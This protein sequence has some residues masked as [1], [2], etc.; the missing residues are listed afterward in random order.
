M[1]VDRR[2]A[3]HLVHALDQ[4]IRDRVLELFRFLV[5]LVPAHAENLHQEELDQPVAAQ[6]VES[7]TP[8]GLR[9]L[10]T[11]VG[12]VV[13]QTALRQGL[14]HRRDRAWRDAQIVGDAPHADQPRGPGLR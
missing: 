6:N 5:D 1:R 13:D 7:E 2:E 4:P 8:P 14:A 3:E 11:A 10:H 12:H 9:E